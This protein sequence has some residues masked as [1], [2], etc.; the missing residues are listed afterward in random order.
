MARSGC[1]FEGG[2]TQMYI[3]RDYIFLGST[4][5]VSTA[6]GRHATLDGVLTD[7]YSVGINSLTSLQSPDYGV[8]GYTG[9]AFYYISASTSTL[10]SYVSFSWLRVGLV[11]FEVRLLS[12]GFMQLLRG[13]TVV[14]TSPSVINPS[15]GHWIECRG[16]LINSGGVVVIWV[17]GV[18]VVNYTG[19]TQNTAI[20]GWDR[21]SWLIPSIA[22]PG[23]FINDI[24]FTDDAPVVMGVP[25]PERW[26]AALRPSADVTVAGI[27]ATPAQPG[28]SF[29]LNISEAPAS[30]ASYLET[31]TSP[32]ETLFDATNLPAPAAVGSVEVVSVF[33]WQGRDGVIT[34]GESRLRS[35]ATDAYSAVTVLPAAPNYGTTQLDLTL[36]P[37][38]GLTWTTAGIDASQIGN[39]W[40]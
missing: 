29:Y 32:N 36:D 35:V 14:A 7:T 5:V 9:A 39:R 10:P 17:D 4:A 21:F 16:T 12:S 26:C 3:D 25:M 22:G 18:E 34:T 8:L 23:C 37:D 27:T 24:I 19:D 13:G 31:V 6:R 1:S 11:N 40:A 38:T 30:I 2:T 20:A 33:A 28:G 15:V